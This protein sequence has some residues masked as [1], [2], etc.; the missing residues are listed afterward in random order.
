MIDVFR[1]PT[2]NWEEDDDDSQIRSFGFDIF[3]SPQKFTDIFKEI[4]KKCQD[5]LKRLVT[6]L[7]A[8]SFIHI[9]QSQTLITTKESKIYGTDS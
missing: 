9:H 4:W 6:C 8:I 5:C 1:H 3:S 2:W 7:E